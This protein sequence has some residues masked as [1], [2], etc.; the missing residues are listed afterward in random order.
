MSAQDEQKFRFVEKI[1]PHKDVDFFPCLPCL[2]LFAAYELL[3][4]RVLLLW[5]K[6]IFIDTAAIKKS[7]EKLVHEWMN[8]L[9]MLQCLLPQNWGILGLVRCTEDLNILY[10]INIY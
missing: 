9:S 4:K 8:S 5:L 7:K 1:F 10:I 3:E 2:N 6:T